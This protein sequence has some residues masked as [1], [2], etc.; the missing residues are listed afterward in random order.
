MPVSSLSLP[1]VLLSRRRSPAPTALPSPQAKSACQQ[2]LLT[3]GTTILRMPRDGKQAGSPIPSQDVNR[4]MPPLEQQLTLKSGVR[5]TAPALPN[6]KAVSSCGRILC[7]QKSSGKVSRLLLSSWKN[8]CRA[9]GSLICRGRG[10]GKW[11]HWVRLACS[12]WLHSA[13]W[14]CQ[15]DNQ[16][17]GGLD[18]AVSSLTRKWLEIQ[19]VLVLP[20]RGMNF[21]I[22]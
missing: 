19:Q 8:F 11:G 2:S 18:D 12:S 17:N 20:Y 3:L 15:Q 22:C 6:S 1:Q 10:K 7:R 21:Q 9:A 16:C 13:L 5:M 14:G 4:G